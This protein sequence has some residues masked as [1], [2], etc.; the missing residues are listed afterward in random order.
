MPDYTWVG[1]TCRQ[2]EL[3]LGPSKGGPHRTHAIPVAAASVGRP[4]L[5]GDHHHGVSA[6]PRVWRAATT[7]PD[8][9]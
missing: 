2:H 1:I 9:H 8:R 3:V 6:D 5:K 4:P 7:N